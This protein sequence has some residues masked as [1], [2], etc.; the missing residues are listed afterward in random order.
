VLAL[1]GR[2]P[3]RRGKKLRHHPAGP[4]AAEA[5]PQRAQFRPSLK[6]ED[7]PSTGHWRNLRPWNGVKRHKPVHPSRK[8]FGPV[9][10]IL[11]PIPVSSAWG[12]RANARKEKVEQAV[13]RDS[14]GKHFCWFG[15]PS[16]RHVCDNPSTAAA[17]GH[18]PRIARCV[19]RAPERELSLCLCACGKT[20]RRGGGGE[21]G[22]GKGGERENPR[23]EKGKASYLARAV[24][25][26]GSLLPS[27]PQPIPLPQWQTRLFSC[28]C[29]QKSTGG[30]LPSPQGLG[31]QPSPITG[32][33]W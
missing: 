29:C 12:K 20:R 24:T 10:F 31:R 33:R 3:R 15:R 1:E 6:R 32:I 8:G 28:V 18:N 11:A 25:P 19:G 21:G 14:P 30:D 4:S 26:A 2:L 13:A 27:A 16:G 5:A 17:C 22:G 9:R 23:H 7:W